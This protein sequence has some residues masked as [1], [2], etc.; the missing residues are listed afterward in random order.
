MKMADPWAAFVAA[1]LDEAEAVAKAAADGGSWSARGP[2]DGDPRANFV[3]REDGHDVAAWITSEDAAHI[4]R[5]DPA[6]ALH[7]AAAKRAVLFHC[8]FCM[9]ERE[10]PDGP[11]SPRAALARLIVMDL[12]SE[13]P[14]HPDHPAKAAGPGAPR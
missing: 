13:W 11:A 7:G 12:A 10:A 2:Y 1:R 14:A 5:Y 3:V 4:A 8:Q 9:G 6:W